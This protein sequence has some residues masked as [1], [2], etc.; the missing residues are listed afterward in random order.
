MTRTTPATSP[1]PTEPSPQAGPG[2]TPASPSPR[3]AG[4]AS[5]R[6]AYDL[7]LAGAIGALLGLYLYVELVQASSVNVRD[8]LAGL[9]IGG[10]VG[11]FLGACGPFRDGAWRRLARAVAWGVPAAAIG[12]AL[13]LVLG[14]QVIGLFQ[15]G[16]LGRACSWAVLGLGIGVGQG[17]AGRSR[18][19]LVMGLI[20]GGIG[21]FVGG[22]S[23]EAI[24]VAMG[25]RTELGQALGIVI[26]GAGLG[27]SLA[28]VEQALRRAW[29]QVLS[30]RQ[31][32]R[33]YLL[34]R[35]ICRLG[36]DERAE[37]GIFGDPGVARQH[38]RIL[39]GPHG[40]AIEHLA[41]A[42][43]SRLNGK[44]FTGTETLRDGDRIELGQ[45]VLLFR[46]R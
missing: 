46:Q 18:Q 38:A 24:R 29:I 35:P 23:F 32:G 34:D 21:G 40:Y 14:E 39:G 44:A 19:R 11:S 37:V 15:G 30:G 22:M 13:G 42:A 9:L 36:L 5:R 25:N 1:R 20:G 27:L 3:L 10:S 43:S 7:A 28:L 2:S 41:A 4:R 6:Q 33:T 16:I 45:T 17:I 31:E 12:G 8:A 26:L